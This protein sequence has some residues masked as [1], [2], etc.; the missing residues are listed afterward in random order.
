MIRNYLKNSPLLIQYFDLV[1]IDG[2]ARN[3]CI[4]NVLQKLKYRGYLIVDNFHRQSYAETL[5]L[6]SEW[7][8]LR[9]FGASVNSKIFTQT[10]FFKKLNNGI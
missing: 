6:I 7:Q 2:E 3:S 9:S 8:I 1:L 10:S 4:K 5:S